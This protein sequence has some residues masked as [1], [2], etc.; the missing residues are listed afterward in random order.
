MPSTRT[1]FSFA[2]L[3]TNAPVT[4]NVRN[5]R[6]NMRF[7][8]ENII[9]VL[10][11]VLFEAWFLHGYFSGNPEFEPAIGFLA[12]LGALFTKDTIKSRLG[13]GGDVNNHDIQLFKEFQQVFPVEP[14]LRLLK[15]TDFGNSFPQESIRPLYSFVDS[16]DSVDKEFLNQKLEKERKSLYAAAKDLA[17]EFVKQ[18]GPVGVGDYVS[19][20]PDNLR[21]DAR[22]DHVIESARI[23]NEKSIKFTPR[24]EQ[25]V[26]KCKTILNV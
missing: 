13:F 7:T 20:F 11:L 2:T 19:V 1:H 15:E 23:L 3:S 21:G 17:L 18:T 6:K 5:H 24:Y 8:I 22:P 14:T 26:R 12:A 4:E 25:F 10:L 9:V 16:W